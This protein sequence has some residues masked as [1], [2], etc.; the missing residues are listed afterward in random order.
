MTKNI[1]GFNGCLNLQSNSSENYYQIIN[2][3]KSKFIENTAN[4][5]GSI[6]INNL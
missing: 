2:I 4:M 5:G 1:C 6:Y 3:K